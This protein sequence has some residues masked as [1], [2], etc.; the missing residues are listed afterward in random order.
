M[1][2]EEQDFVAWSLYTGPG[3]LGSILPNDW[4]RVVGDWSGL[5]T[6]TLA[7]Q[8]KK[9]I[10]LRIE[11]LLEV[12]SQAQKEFITSDRHFVVP[13][14]FFRCNEGPY[15]EVVLNCDGHKPFEYIK[16]QLG[17][18]ITDLLKREPDNSDYTIFIGTILTCN[19]AGGCD[20]DDFLN[21]EIVKGRQDE[22][23]GILEPLVM[24]G[25]NKLQIDR[26]IWRR[27]YSVRE[28]D[29]ELTK[30]PIKRNVKNQI[31]HLMNRYYHNPLCT[32][33]NRG[34][35]IQWDKKNR[36]PSIYIHEKQHLSSIDLTMGRFVDNTLIHGNQ[37]TE[38][39]A[40]YPAYSIDYGDKQ[41][42]GKHVTKSR[43]QKFEKEI[44]IKHPGR[45]SYEPFL[46]AWEEKQVVGEDIGIE[47]CVDHYMQRLRRTV[48]MSKA[49][50]AFANNYPLSK[51]IIPSC[52]MQLYD[53][54]VCADSERPIFNADGG[55]PVFLYKNSDATLNGKG[56]HKG[57]TCGV[58]G[59]SIQSDWP[60]QYNSHS[61]LAFTLEGPEVPSYDM[62]LGQFNPTSSTNSESE[63]LLKN[64]KI[65]SYQ[66]KRLSICVTNE[67]V[68]TQRLFAA[69][70]GEL[71]HYYPVAHE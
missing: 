14:F 55:A 40:N 8:I 42:D 4:S 52:S 50:G 46:P 71:H 38:W 65:E 10:D 41:F 2:V 66:A 25:N 53:F 49:K 7:D 5:N 68:R 26:G 29:I 37:I 33:R 57:V 17:E 62:G 21:S 56:V 45:T 70:I 44:T 58:Y 64:S 36:T 28:E 69:G 1:K 60:D 3:N 23:N 48:G 30:D 11:L 34:I 35:S 63:E 39:M 18:K 19:I 27:S 16:N 20:F 47:I 43:I 6:N 61:Q 13:E 24:G 67:K 54:A 59:L 15:P 9:D 31:E 12:F 51:Q 22:L 32:V